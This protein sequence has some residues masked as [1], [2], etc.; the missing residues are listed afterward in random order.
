MIA[1]LPMA[2]RWQC[3]RRSRAVLCGEV[4]WEPKNVS[5]LLFLKNLHSYCLGLAF[6]LLGAMV[7]CEWDW[8]RV[9]RRAD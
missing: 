3:G 8:K 9:A 4:P 1:W 5:F 2:T 7:S 6:L